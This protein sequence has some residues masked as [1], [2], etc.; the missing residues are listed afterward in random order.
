MGIQ[1]NRALRER[2]AESWKQVAVIV[3]GGWGAERFASHQNY[4]RYQALFTEVADLNEQIER[5]EGDK[6]QGT[7]GRGREYGAPPPGA[8]P[9][10][11]LGY[12]SS[13][14]RENNKEHREAFQ[15]YLRI[16]ASEMRTDQRAVLF[17]RRDMG[18]GGQGAYPGATTGFFVPVGFFKQVEDALKYYG[19]MLV[20]GEGMPLLFDTDTGAPLPFPT[21]DDTNEIGEQVGENQQVTTADVSLGQIMFG[22]WKYSTKMVKVSIELLT[23]SAF[24]IESFLA[25]E[26]GRRLGRIANLKTTTGVGTTEP[27]GIVPAI[28]AGGNVITATGSFT[29]DDVGEANTIGSDDLV[30]L[31][32]QVDPVYRPRA[33]YMM[34]DA[35]LKALKKVKDKNGRSLLWQ[36]GTPQGSPA[37]V[38]GYPY[39]I[40]NDMDQLQTVSSS[41]VVTRR[42]MV[43]GDLS[44]HVIRRVKQLSVLR[45]SERFA[46]FGQVAFI[47]FARYDANNI[48]VGHRAQAILQN[49][50]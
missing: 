15:T 10:D 2:R 11:S 36:E 24:D 28:T 42:T 43:F 48:D 19:P 38:N 17:E 50:Y 34:H 3:R 14:G 47:G 7:E 21:A 37:T 30:A 5:S 39:C 9:H 22:A 27:M 13:E 16:G 4:A 18:T 8:P 35:T 49:V 32:H 31:E 12:S 33:R 45:L 6:M 1:E 23:D 41:P 26:F 20:G 40:N 29:N 44:K 25:T 46:D